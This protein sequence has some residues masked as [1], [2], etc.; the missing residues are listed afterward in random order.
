MARP[1]K[2]NVYDRI[3][4]QKAKIQD[5]ENLLKQLNEELQILFAERDQLEMELIFKQT[6]ESGLSFDEVMNLLKT[7]I[8]K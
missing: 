4:E 3:V 1:A 7:N 2:K 5:A 8:A 6:K